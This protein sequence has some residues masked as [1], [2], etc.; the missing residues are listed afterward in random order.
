MDDAGISH[1]SRS[2]QPS[3]SSSASLYGVVQPEKPNNDKGRRIAGWLRDMGAEFLILAAMLAIVLFLLLPLLLALVAGSV[4]SV[5]CLLALVGAWQSFQAAHYPAIANDFPTIENSAK[6][7]FAGIS[8]LA[9]LFALNVLIAGLLGHRRQHLYLIPGLLLTF[10]ALVLF[11]ISATLIIRMAS[12]ITGQPELP[13]ALFFGYAGVVAVVLALLLTDLRA[14]TRRASRLHMLR[15][16][17]AAQLGRL[18]GSRS[19]STTANAAFRPTV[20]SLAHHRGTAHWKYEGQGRPC[21]GPQRTRNRRDAHRCNCHA[22]R[23]DKT[24]R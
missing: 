8:Y 9:L 6:I 1:S 5:T 13:F 24:D 19:P 17:F 15:L 23:T 7:A 11:T 22:D 3:R 12:G 20:G 18:M 14:K 4:G 21:A 2:S 10:P 16:W